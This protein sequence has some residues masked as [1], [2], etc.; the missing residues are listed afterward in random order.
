MMSNWVSHAPGQCRETDPVASQDPCPAVRGP[1]LGLSSAS[2]SVSH[3]G[4]G[5]HGP[6]LQLCKVP[7][8]LRTSPLG[9][10]LAWS[11]IL[12]LLPTGYQCCSLSAQLSL[13][14][15]AAG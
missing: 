5:V 7:C 8:L 2:L 4:K 11:Y 10:R 15:C 6:E 3:Q 12:R 1:Y 13:G 14:V 9:A